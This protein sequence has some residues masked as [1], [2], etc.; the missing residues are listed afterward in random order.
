MEFTAF[1]DYVVCVPY[2][3]GQLVLAFFVGNGKEYVTVVPV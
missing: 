1:L 2:K 3:K